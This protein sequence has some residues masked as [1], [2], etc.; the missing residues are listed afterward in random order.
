MQLSAAFKQLSFLYNIYVKLF[1]K[2]TF[3]WIP[4]VI[5]AGFQ[6]MAWMSGPIFLS[7]LSLVPRVLV[8]LLFACG[9]YIFM[10]PSMNIAV[11]VLKMQEPLLVTIY[12]VV[13]LVVY[14]FMHT[15]VFKKHFQPKF[16]VSFAL[17]AAAVYVAY[18]W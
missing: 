15:F 13:T 4:L 17:L 7:S 9:E 12:Q 1:P 16:F 14:I 18:M 6:S 3:P 8:L 5:A 2:W 10:S 11:E